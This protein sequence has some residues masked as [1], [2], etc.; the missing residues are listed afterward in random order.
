MAKVANVGSWRR[1]S[2]T[3]AELLA[4]VLDLAVQRQDAIFEGHMD[5]IP[6]QVDAG[7]LNA[8]YVLEHL[9]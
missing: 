7:S 8:A 6:M 5:G 1:T 2:P 3:P 4:N 9:F